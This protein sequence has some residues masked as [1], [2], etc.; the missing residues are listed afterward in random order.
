MIKR[1]SIKNVSLELL[2][3]Y[4]RNPM[5]H[6]SNM[7]HIVNSIKEF[8]YIKTS[9]VVD[10]NDVLL[11]GHGT[12]QAL[13]KLG[14]KEAPEVV[15]IIGLTEHQKKA[16][17]IADNSSAQ[18]G[19]WDLEALDIEMQDIE[20]DMGKFGLDISEEISIEDGGNA[21]VKSKLTDK[22]I[23]PPFSVLDTRQG[24][25][26]ER[27]KMWRK[28]ICDYGESREN[29]LANGLMAGINSG[30]SIL[31]PVLAELANLWFGL[32]GGNTFDCF[33]GDTV[34]GYVSSKLGNNFIGIEI[35]EEQAVLNNERVAGMNCKYICDD[36]QN[37]LKHIPENSQDLFFSCP[38]YFDLEIYSDL[39]NDASNQADYNSFIE[40]IEKAFSNSIKC[41]K[42][43]R[44][45]IVVAGDVRDKNGFYYNFPEDIKKIF[46]KQG[47]KL[48]NEM[49]LVETLGTLPQR[50]Q[51][52]MINRKIGKC[53]QN[54]MVFYKGN[55]K[56]I[57]DV[58]PK[59][60]IK[61]EEVNYES[62]YME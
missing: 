34:F 26:Q 43:N 9:I 31:D 19:E 7:E 59:I 10:E 56:K 23:V 32:S 36:G 12:L 51:K 49:I 41:L 53:H 38:P 27:K 22:F 21:W 29:T 35:R 44:F 39:T 2:K 28:L 50:V 60:D 45:A 58:F 62:N 52:S 42:E 16:Y 4:E 48:Y 13:K 55:T 3:P 20:F 15:K 8:G 5:K 54:I 46:F 18:G 47:L 30:V 57:K 6:D 33:A 11:T 24:Y 37:V 14:Y 40:I 25:W 1:E 61:I 17:R